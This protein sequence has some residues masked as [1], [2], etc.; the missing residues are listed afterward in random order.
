MN[1]RPDPWRNVP[2]V[3][4]G[5]D[6][7]VLVPGRPCRLGGVVL[8]SEVGPAGHSDGDVL[9]HALTDAL[10][11]GA[12]LDDLGT[13]FPDT[14]PRWKDADSGTFLEEALERC[15]ERGLR[16]LSADLVLVCD[17]PR[18]APHRPLL[19]RALARRLD[20]PED[21]VNLKGKTW[22]GR[23][24]ASGLCQVQAVVLLGPDPETG[25]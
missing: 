5:L 9:L 7:H 4:L 10:L 20:L 16:P 1:A 6:T 13:L 24:E 12:G 14:A 11:G 3:G 19:R 25:A 18:I 2:R 8:D 17:R 15:R 22:E 23:S 21:R